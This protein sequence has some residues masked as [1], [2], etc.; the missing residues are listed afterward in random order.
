MP[1]DL[2]DTD[3]LGPVG[4]Q[5]NAN[6]CYAFT[7]CRAIEYKH[8][9][10]TNNDI[11]LSVQDIYQNN[12]HNAEEEKAGLSLRETFEWMKQHGCLSE[13][14]CPYVHAWDVPPMQDRENHIEFYVR[15][16]KIE[17]D[18]MKD[19]LKTT[20]P[21]CVSVEWIDKEMGSL[22]GDNIYEGPDD[23]SHFID[24]PE[25]PV[26]SHTLLVIGY[27]S[28]EVNGRK[29]KY[30]IVQNSHG[31]GWGNNGFSRFSMEIKGLDGLLINEGMVPTEIIYHEPPSK[32]KKREKVP[33]QSTKKHKKLEK[34]DK[35]SAKKHKKLEKRDKRSAKSTTKNVYPHVATGF[36]DTSAFLRELTLKSMLVLALKLS[37]RTLSGSLL[38]HLSKLQVDEEP[39]IRTNTTILLGNIASCLNEGTRKRVLINAFTVGAFRDTFPPARGAGIMALCATSSNYDITEMILPNVVLTIDPDSDVRS[40]AFQAIDQFL[41]MAKQHYEKTNIAE[42]TGAAGMDNSI[43]GNASLL[44][45]AW[46]ELENGIDEEPENDKDGWD[47]LEPLEETKPTPV[48]TN[49]QAAQRRPVSHAKAPILQPKSTPKLSMDED[50]DLWGALATPAPKTSKPLNLKSTTATD[51]DGPWAAIAAPAPTTRAKPLSA[52]RGRGAK[53]AAPKL[54]AQRISLT[55]SRT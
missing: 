36:S 29:I 3:Y 9:K 12:I 50:D 52:G 20:G 8:K 11:S 5:G 41:Q 39:A 54:G 45:Y 51:D 27:G 15:S 40:K 24:T 18:D 32:K 47:D 25:S 35:T 17:L 33:S 14:S 2:R 30:W 31:T 44:E 22:R 4:N 7:A 23:V 10:E 21:I 1:V 34:R 37:Q 13:D 42:T 19:Y 28:E 53:P 49:I 43:P 46:G 16:K 48:L 38:K 55:S 6:T 26:G